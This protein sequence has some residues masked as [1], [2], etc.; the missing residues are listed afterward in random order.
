[1]TDDEVAAFANKYGYRIASPDLSPLGVSL[2]ILLACGP[3]FRGHRL[4]MI[5]PFLL[6]AGG[7]AFLFCL[8]YYFHIF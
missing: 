2:L 5:V 4:W 8:A 7:L 3:A 6:N 1:M